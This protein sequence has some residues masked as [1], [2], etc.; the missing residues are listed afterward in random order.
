MKSL[1]GEERRLY[2]SAVGCYFYDKFLWFFILLIIF[3]PLDFD[4]RTRLCC[5][6][7]TNNKGNQ[8]STI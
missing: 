5:G 3:L 1:I 8:I 6:G 7:Y 4:F 2:V